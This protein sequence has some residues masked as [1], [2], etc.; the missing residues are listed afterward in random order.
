MADKQPFLS[1]T[2]LFFQLSQATATT[3]M[4]FTAAV[5][6]LDLLK[7]ITL[8]CISTLLLIG[9]ETY[10]GLQTV[11]LYVG[12]L[13]IFLF[14]KLILAQMMPDFQVIED[15][16]AVAAMLLLLPIHAIQLKAFFMWKRRVMK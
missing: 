3:Y 2:F 11:L 10:K 4:P 6:L 1:N 12:L 15:W 13:I 9:M 7:L 14:I 5:I 16:Y 8:T